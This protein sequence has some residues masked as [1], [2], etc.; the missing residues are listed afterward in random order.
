MV[1]FQLKKLIKSQEEVES[2]MNLSALLFFLK[3]NKKKYDISNFC[4]AIV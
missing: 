1:A 4:M 2:E 3:K